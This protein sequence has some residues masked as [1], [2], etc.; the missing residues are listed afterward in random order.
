[1]GSGYLMMSGS[2]GIADS[3]DRDAQD[4]RASL[5]ALCSMVG[6]NDHESLRQ[7]AHLFD[8]FEVAG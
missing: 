7:T 5:T 8:A 6:I 1:M 2:S 4:L 3:E